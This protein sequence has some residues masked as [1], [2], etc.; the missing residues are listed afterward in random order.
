MHSAW[1]KILEP[2][3]FI[4]LITPRS[5]AHTASGYN[6]LASLIRYSEHSSL[7]KEESFGEIPSTVNKRMTVMYTLQVL[8]YK[9]SY[10]AIVCAIYS[11]S[12][13]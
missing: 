4:R 7:P 9:V 3:W 2:E 5:T 8:Y 12:K 11:L 10:R 1:Q 6:V 13:A